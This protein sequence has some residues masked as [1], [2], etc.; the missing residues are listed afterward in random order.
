L[1]N[2]IQNTQLN[3]REPKRK[4]TILDPSKYRGELGAAGSTL[5]ANTEEVFVVNGFVNKAD[6]NFELA[7]KIAKIDNTGVSIGSF[8]QTDY[9]VSQVKSFGCNSVLDIMSNYRSVDPKTEVQMFKKQGFNYVILSPVSDVDEDEYCRSA[10]Q[11]A[12]KLE[13]LINKQGQ[14]VFLHDFTGISRA[15][16]ILMVYFAVMCRHPSWENLDELRTQILRNWEVAQPNVTIVRLVLERQREY[17]LAAQQ[18][19]EQDEANARAGKE[20]EKRKNELENAQLEAEILRLKRLAEAEA[21]AIRLQRAKFADD[22]KAR[23]KKL[24]DEQKERDRLADERLQAH[25]RRMRELEDQERE[26]EAQRR[27]KDEQNRVEDEK[28]RVSR[29]QEL[30]AARKKLA[31]KRE[32]VQKLLDKKA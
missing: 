16:T 14:H 30:E 32:E 15:P 3:E 9:D 27:I 29:E 28:I 31:A 21:E 23:L 11:A 18:R 1:S 2:R 20:D 13:E 8:P 12:L 6:G 10:F 25:L 24:D 22:E 5:W 26:R 17:H 19:F 4:F 7:F